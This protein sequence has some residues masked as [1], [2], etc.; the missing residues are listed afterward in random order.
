MCLNLLFCVS[1]LTVSAIRTLVIEYGAHLD[2]SGWSHLEILNWRSLH[3]CKDPNK[4]TFT[5]S[6]GK[7]L[8][9]SFWGFCSTH[10]GAEWS[11]IKDLDW[12][13]KDR[14]DS[15]QKNQGSNWV[16]LFWGQWPHLSKSEAK[17]LCE[18][19]MRGQVLQDPQELQKSVDRKAELNGLTRKSHH[20]FLS[21]GIP[22]LN[23]CVLELRA[24]RV[25]GGLGEGETGGRRFTI[26]VWVWNIEV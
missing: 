20:W 6:G 10:H 26:P 18:Q 15:E 8:D 19:M 9:I 22:W 12:P 11:K 5:G 17:G 21:K 23:Q 14:E 13:F 7:Y 1:P 3:I 25:I 2:N 16:G 4:V 24:G